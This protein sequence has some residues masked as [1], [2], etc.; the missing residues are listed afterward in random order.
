MREQGRERDGEKSKKGGRCTERGGMW[1]SQLS[2]F[3]QPRTGWGAGP[4]P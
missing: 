4:L 3:S 1:D 2:P